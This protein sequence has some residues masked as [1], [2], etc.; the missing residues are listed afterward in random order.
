M[1][2]NQEMLARMQARMDVN[3]KDMKEAVRTNQEKMDT[4]LKEII[5]EIRAL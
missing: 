3:L 1:I 4:N 2:S 5:A